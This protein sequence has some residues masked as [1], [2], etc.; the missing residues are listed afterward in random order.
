MVNALAALTAA[1]KD[2]VFVAATAITGICAALDPKSH[3][4]AAPVAGVAKSSAGGEDCVVGALVPCAMAAAMLACA[5]ASL[6]ADDAAALGTVP[7]RAAAL[8]SV[9]VGAQVAAM[10]ALLAMGSMGLAEGAASAGAAA[11]RAAAAEVPAA[12]PTALPAALPGKVFES[13]TAAAPAAPSAGVMETPG[14]MPGA[15]TAW[16]PAP[17]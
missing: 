2:A 7:L 6:S 8:A 15:P 11:T 1:V 3:C 5:A 9:E 16:P 10:F 14:G 17:S 13:V 12:L 4:G